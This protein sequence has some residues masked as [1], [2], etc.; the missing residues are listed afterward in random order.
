M[1]TDEIKELIF[2][3]T[4]EIYVIN[5]ESLTKDQIQN[6]IDNED[7]YQRLVNKHGTIMGG[8]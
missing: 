5:K 8:V 3:L 2:I 1:S 4:Y 7:K 6:L